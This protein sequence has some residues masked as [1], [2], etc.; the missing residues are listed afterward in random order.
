METFGL[1]P[2]R[3]VGELK[4]A[5]MEAILEGTIKNEMEPA[6]AFLLQQGATMGLAPE[7]GFVHSP[8]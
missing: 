5:V 4:E 6:L 1:K 7:G 8:N 2:S 3:Q